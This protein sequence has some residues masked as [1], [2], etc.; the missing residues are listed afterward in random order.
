MTED[1]GPA[2]DGG[3]DRT[4]NHPDEDT[5]PDRSRDEAAPDEF[6]DPNVAGEMLPDESVEP[7]SPTAENAF[8]VALGVVFGIAAIVS[9]VGLI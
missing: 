6:A 3:A 7:G 4:P 9:M 5:E 8:F 1:D 2:D